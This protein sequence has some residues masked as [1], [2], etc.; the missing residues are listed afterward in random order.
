[1]TTD[2]KRKTNVNHVD[3][4]SNFQFLGDS[5]LVRFAE[6]ILN[7]PV[8]YINNKRSIN[9]LCVGGQTI[10]QLL[11]AVKN[12]IN[13]I[14]PDILCMIGTN[15]LIKGDDTN[16]MLNLMQ[17]LVE[18]LLQN[19]ANVTLLTIPPVPKLHRMD[20]DH[21]QKLWDF[22]YSL[23]KFNEF[24]KVQVLDIAPLFL[25]NNKYH[26]KERLFEK[27]IFLRVM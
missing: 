19:N 11:E 25:T 21:L 14:G 10:E 4:L 23:L 7:F 8:V 22:N 12:N 2:T 3:N 5:N 20:K 17:S 24:E 15:N 6:K 27:E 13:E 16:H 26:I 18:V 1:M 9:K